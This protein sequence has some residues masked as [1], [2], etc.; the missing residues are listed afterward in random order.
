MSTKRLTR[1]EL[2]DLLDIALCQC[3]R[4]SDNDNVYADD[5]SERDLNI[6]DVRGWLA[7]EPEPELKTIADVRGWLALAIV[8]FDDLE[9]EPELKTESCG[10][11]TNDDGTPSDTTLTMLRGSDRSKWPTL[12]CGVC[13]Y[14]QC[15]G[16]YCDLCGGALWT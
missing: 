9:P 2:V 11:L 6:K 15:D 8:R 7:L 14:T 4:D 5:G 13:Q 10:P 16:T 3:E 12:Q 1:S